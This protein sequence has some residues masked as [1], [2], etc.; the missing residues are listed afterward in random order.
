MFIYYSFR[1]LLDLFFSIYMSFRKRFRY[2]YTGRPYSVT[3]VRGKLSA[4]SIL[5]R[6]TTV[7]GDVIV[8][9]SFNKFPMGQKKIVFKQKLERVP[10]EIL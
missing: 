7:N 8:T 1:R 2:S 3:C 5:L 4:K 6:K 9:D 10:L